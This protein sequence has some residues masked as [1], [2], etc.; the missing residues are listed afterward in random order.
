MFSRR[1]TF[2]PLALLD[3]ALDLLDGIVALSPANTE[4]LA[5]ML[6]NPQAP[7][8]APPDMR[9]AIAV[10]AQIYANSPDDARSTLDAIAAIPAGKQSVFSMPAVAESFEK[11]FS[12]S[13]D[14]RRGFGFGRFAVEN[15]WTN[16]RTDAIHGIAEEFMAAPAG[17]SHV[18]VQP[19]LAPAIDG[20]GAFS[21]AGDTYI[22]I[23][24]VWNDED[25][26]ETNVG[27]L[28]RMRSRLDRHAA[29][30]YIN[31]INAANGVD[32][33]K[34]CY[35]AE[36]WERLRGIRSEWDPENLFHDFPGV[37]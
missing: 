7:P 8:D 28:N 20:N 10:R 17:H 2:F 34:A 37:S 31:E 36:S 26:D 29:G 3:I 18:V 13:M 35:S 25:T 30:H 19:K 9:K 1:R 5:L 23:Y 22:G 11:L 6:H 27:W 16:E 33:V 32:R 12:D 24:G 4:L 21:A 15:A 14:W